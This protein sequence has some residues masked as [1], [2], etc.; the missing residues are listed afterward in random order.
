MDEF[1]KSAYGRKTNMIDGLFVD[2]FIHMSSHGRI[3]V[4]EEWN[5]IW[6][7]HKEFL[8]L[9]I[10]SSLAADVVSPES[11]DVIIRRLDH[12]CIGRTRSGA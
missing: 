7:D 10:F 1:R 8:D 9:D 4:M 12:V 2:Q 3:L 5:T 11:L 6:E